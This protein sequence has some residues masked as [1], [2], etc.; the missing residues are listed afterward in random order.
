VSARRSID[1]ALRLG[2][3]QPQVALSAGWIHEQ[4]GDLDDADRWYAAALALDPRIARDLFWQSE[5]RVARW[6][7]IRD[8]AFAAL[9]PADQVALWVAAGDLDAA[10][11]ATR[12]VVDGERRAFLELVVRASGDD[13]AGR[14]ELA[15]WTRD[16]PGDVDGVTWS[17]RIFGRAGDADA[18]RRYREWADILERGAGEAGFDVAIELPPISTATKTGITSVAWGAVTY[19]RP[20]PD[21]QVLSDLPHLV[22]VP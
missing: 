13:P 20:T 16:H 3:Q 14:A 2:A 4:L 8:L 12:A 18:A 6:G 19:R 11:G 5:V 22:L 17:A 21:D 7:H 15:Q 9:S 1:R 10:G